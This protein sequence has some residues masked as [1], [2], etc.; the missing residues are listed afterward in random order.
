MV[1]GR[2]ALVAPATLAP[3]APR[4]GLAKAAGPAARAEAAAPARSS[5]SPTSRRETPTPASPRRWRFETPTRSSSSAPTRAPAPVDGGTDGGAL[6]GDAMFVQMFDPVTGNKRGPSKFLFSVPYGGSFGVQDVA[7]A[8]TGEIALL[9]AVASQTNHYADQLY[10]TIL[11]A[12]PGD[13]G[14]AALSV[15]KTVQLESV[16]IGDAH[17][18]WQ[19]AAQLF[20]FSWKYQGSNGAGTRAFASTTR[21]DRLRDCHQ[22]VSRRRPSLRARQPRMTRTSA[23]RGRTSALPTSR[24]TT[25]GPTSRSWTATASRSVP[26]SPCRRAASTTGWPAPARRP[27]S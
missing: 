10:M 5:S 19:P 25:T 18:I 26:S 8:P 24:G 13:G 2:A 21:R 17:V 3:A 11:G 6:A 7:I 9:Y 4:A 22:R 16:Y 12:T 14:T 1:S 27:A 20:V 23:C 15:Q